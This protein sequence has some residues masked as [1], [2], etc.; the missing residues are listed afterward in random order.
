M[1][2]DTSAK[3]KLDERIKGHEGLGLIQ[4]FEGHGKGKSTAAL[5]TAIRAMGAGHNVAIVYFD[6]GGTHYF[7]REMLAKCPELIEVHGTGRDRID[8]DTGR[9]DFEITDEDKLEGKRGLEIAED[10]FARNEHQLVILDEINSS[11]SLGIVDEKAVLELIDKKPPHVEL[12]LTGRDA[13][14]SLRE[15]AHLITEMTLKKHYFYSG[16]GAREGIDF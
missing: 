1:S 14:E 13:P 7:E 10:I 6:K 4:L 16:V 12:I 5:G 9:F 3:P 11:A 15:C 8:P 2:Q